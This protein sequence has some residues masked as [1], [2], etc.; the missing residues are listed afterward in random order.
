LKYNSF[1]VLDGWWNLG[2]VGGNDLLV[3]QLPGAPVVVVV[4]VE[5]AF[6]EEVLKECP[7]IGVIWLLV[8]SKVPD[9]GEVGG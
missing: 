9:V 7:Q 1:R 6:G 5:T 2:L 8:K 3:R 4:H